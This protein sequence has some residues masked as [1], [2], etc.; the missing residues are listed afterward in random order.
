M[1]GAASPTGR[2][3]VGLYG[4]QRRMS[5]LARNPRMVLESLGVSEE[6]CANLALGLEVEDYFRTPLGG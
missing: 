1:R 2:S 4:E 6:T 3:L 5:W